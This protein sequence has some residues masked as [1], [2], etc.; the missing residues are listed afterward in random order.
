[1]MQDFHLIAPRL[2]LDTRGRLFEKKASGAME[3]VETTRTQAE[4]RYVARHVKG[5]KT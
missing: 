4:E 5:A 3:K 1:M 2:Y